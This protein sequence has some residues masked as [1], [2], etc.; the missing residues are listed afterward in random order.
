MSFG[1]VRA[2]PST[3]DA[4]ELKRVLDLLKVPVQ[5]FARHAG[6][7]QRTAQRYV[8][9]RAKIPCWVE[10]HLLTYWLAPATRHVRG[11]VALPFRGQWY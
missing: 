6:I 3:L 5:R 7:N 11:R 10:R 1:R 8:D 2:K 4:R 9:G